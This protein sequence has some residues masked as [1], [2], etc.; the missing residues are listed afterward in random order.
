MI[1]GARGPAPTPTAI[2]SMRGSA[3]AAGRGDEVQGP[4]GSPD[5]PGW[6]SESATDV[7]HE[8]VPMLM[9]MG[10]LSKVDGNAL[11]R[12]CEIWIRWRRAAEFLA[13]VPSEFYEVRTLASGKKELK[14]LPMVAIADTLSTQ[15]LRL[16]QQFGMTPSARVGLEVTAPPA[17]EEGMSVEDIL[18]MGMGV[19]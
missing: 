9:Q 11:A 7:W 16:E 18:G 2:L 17:S 15:L 4:P 19:G 14:P 5:P 10:V 8:L 13:S 1:M 12:Y 6:L 3:R